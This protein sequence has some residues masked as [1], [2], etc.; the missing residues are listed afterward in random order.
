MVQS[1]CTSHWE[2]MKERKWEQVFSC[3]VND[4]F[5]NSTIVRGAAGSTRAT[6][7][8]G[9]TST[10]WF[11]VNSCPERR[12]TIKPISINLVHHLLSTKLFKK[13]LFRKNHGENYSCSK[14]WCFL[15]FKCPYEILIM[16]QVK[17]IKAAFF[18]T[19]EPTNYLS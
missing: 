16:S 3:L 11:S 18:F 15:N 1:N 2:P 8:M 7:V 9:E 4:P 13:H 12:H 6:T 10:S 14:R 17:Y 19:A 5:K